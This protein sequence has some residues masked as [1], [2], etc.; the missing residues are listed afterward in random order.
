MP[1]FIKNC[2]HVNCLHN[3]IIILYNDKVLILKQ[4]VIP[5]IYDSMIPVDFGQ[6]N[7]YVISFT[8]DEMISKF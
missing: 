5:P 2:L 6:K 4:E 3:F 7:H 8:S 1:Y